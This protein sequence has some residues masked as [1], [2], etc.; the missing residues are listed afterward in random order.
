MKQPRLQ[1]AIIALNGYYLCDDDRSHISDIDARALLIVTS[2][3]ITAMLTVPLQQLDR[4]IWFGVYPIVTAPLAHESYSK[5]FRQSL[6]IL[7]LLI[8]IGIFNP[9]YDRA[10][11]FTVGNVI[12]SRGWI[13]FIS[14]II[15]GLFA[16]QALLL[17][18]KVKGFFSFCSSLASLGMPQVLVTQLLM[19]YRYLSLLLSEALAMHFA[20]SSRGYR[21]SGYKLKDWQRFIGQLLIRSIDRARRIHLSMKARG[22]LGKLP[23]K[24]QQKW[25]TA[26]TVYCLIWSMLI[27]FLRFYNLSSLFSDYQT[28]S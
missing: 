12:V 28:L 24:P 13:S 16:F 21:A 3:Y 8:L 11:A 15:R 1:K 26:D 23:T 10:T 5:I 6:Y 22:F 18:I 7:P 14:I 27:I 19:L 9:L 17:L 4:L 2:L 25:T 20:R